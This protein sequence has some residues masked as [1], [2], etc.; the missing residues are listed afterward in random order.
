MR[1]QSNRFAA[2][3]M[4]CTLA[5]TLGTN[6]CH[7][8]IPSDATFT[9]QGRLVLSGAPVNGTVSLRFRLFDQAAGGAQ[10][11]GTLGVCGVDVVDGLF[12]VD[13]NFS[14]TAFDGNKRWLEIGVQSPAGNCAN[15]TTLAPRQPLNAAP[16]AVRSLL[17]WETLGANIFYN[18]GNVGIG[19]TGP[20]AT[21]EVSKPNATVRVT[22]TAA[23]GTSQLDLKGDSPSGL[24]SNVLGTIRFLDELNTVHAQISSGKGLFSSPLS[25]A[26]DGTTQMVLTSNGNLGVGTTLPVVKLQVLGGVD[27]EPGSGGFVVLG[28]TNEGNIS[29]D[30]NEIM[31][32]DNGAPSTLFINNDGGD[33]SI[34]A[35][36]GGQVGIGM[37]PGPCTLTV[38]N[39]L[40]VNGGVQ[41][42]IDVG[43]N[44]LILMDTGADI[45]I[46]NGGLEVNTPSG[47][48]T[49]FNRT[50]PDGTLI[51]F[52]NNGTDAGG[53]AVFGSTVS[54]NTFTG[55]H[56]A[57]TETAIE[58]GSL[59]TLTGANVRPHAGPN[60]EV[61]YGV[62]A[63]S[64]AND[65]RC[66]GS[67]LSAADPTDDGSRDLVATVGNG[68]MWVVDSGTG[69]VE[70]GDYLI[71]SDVAGCA[72]LDDTE[73]FAVGHVIARAAEPID[74][75][76]VKAAPGSPKRVL[77]SVFFESFS[78]Q[79]DAVALAETVASLRTENEMLR[80]RLD[81][82]ESRLSTTPL[83]T[84]GGVR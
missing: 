47:G 21:L 8:G 15:F 48:S 76:S 73:R 1:I 12:T 60:C 14:A 67:Y 46:T 64:F 10:I 56:H 58:P 35:S 2:L 84:E 75:S 81:A 23:D 43:P 61:T 78:R 71:S 49:F 69:D 17:P 33:V 32:R 26:V 36:G 63:S 34:L 30:N 18:A 77:L 7:A 54:Y 19:T 29:I 37:A 62:K 22:S 66:L 9:Y 13:L 65:P 44:G 74:W 68:E 6:V 3:V 16:Y 51:S 59:V 40:F 11:G 28:A 72:M 50:N 53:I 4:A 5:V 41:P 55:S 39:S 83:A 31:A 42:R 57:W 24:S 25:F 70:P 38:F 80:A 45:T 52:H 20:A 27:S 79:G 82:I